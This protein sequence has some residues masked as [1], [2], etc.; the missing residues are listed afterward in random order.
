MNKNRKNKIF[1]RGQYKCYLCKSRLGEFNKTIDHVIA[2]RDNGSSKTEN[3]RAC[4]ELCNKMKGICERILPAYLLT[5][6]EI[7][8]LVR[9]YRY[10]LRLKIV[11]KRSLSEN[12]QPCCR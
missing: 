11:Y 12:L 9:A 6:K 8:A 7:D 10:F 1:E 2:R 3:L 5:D 4:C